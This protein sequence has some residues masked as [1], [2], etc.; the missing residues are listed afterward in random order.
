MWS[1]LLSILLGAMVV[2]LGTGYFLYLANKDRKILSAEANQAKLEAQTALENS[3]KAIEE[4]NSKLSEANEQVA[5]AEQALEALKQEQLLLRNAKPLIKPTNK[6]LDGWISAISTAQGVSLLHP[7]GSET[8]VNNDIEFS[9]TENDS[10]VP[11]FRIL[12]FSDSSKR[13]FA[14]L[15]TSST[16]I[17][18]FIDGKLVAGKVGTNKNTDSKSA[19]LNIYANGTSTQVLFIQDPPPF[20]IKSWQREQNISLEE[21]LK[22]IE[23]KK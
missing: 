15:I 11:W 7:P 9:I 12:P 5:K 16:D 23:F 10:D 6:E 19:Y 4:A 1:I 2:G 14:N 20:K 3:Q 8:A 13:Q 21:I 17:A 22:T 18:Y